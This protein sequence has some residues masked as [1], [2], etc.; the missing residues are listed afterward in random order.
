M[1]MDLNVGKT[2]SSCSD[3]ESLKTATV[4]STESNTETKT[5]PHVSTFSGTCIGI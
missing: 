1:S 2:K 3:D 5:T 4:L